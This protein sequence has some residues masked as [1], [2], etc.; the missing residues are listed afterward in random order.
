MGVMD[1]LMNTGN[2]TQKGTKVEQLGQNLIDLMTEFDKTTE[3][4]Y[5]NGLRGKVQLKLST[6]YGEVRDGQ[7]KHAKRVDAVGAAIKKAADRTG[8]MA[9]DVSDKLQIAK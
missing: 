8:T 5:N 1:F 2:I 7:D 6:T 9:Q 3:D 4:M